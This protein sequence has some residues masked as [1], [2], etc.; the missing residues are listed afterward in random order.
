MTYQ[1]REWNVHTLDEIL[2]DWKKRK[3]DVEMSDSVVKWLLAGFQEDSSKL[4]TW[5]KLE[6]WPDVLGLLFD[7][8][9]SLLFAYAMLL[10]GS[11]L[12]TGDK[13][14]YPTLD[15]SPRLLRCATREQF[16]TLK[17]IYAHKISRATLEI[18]ALGWFPFLAWPKLQKDKDWNRKILPKLR[19]R[20]AR[21]PCASAFA[22]KKLL[23]LVPST[24]VKVPVTSRVSDFLEV[25][26]VCTAGKPVSVSLSSVLERSDWWPHH[27]IERDRSHFTQTFITNSAKDGDLEKISAEIA[28]LKATSFLGDLPLQAL[29]LKGIR[30]R[31][32]GHLDTIMRAFQE[33]AN[34]RVVVDN[35]SEELF[36]NRFLKYDVPYSL[37][38]L[39]LVFEKRRYMRN[40]GV[41]VSGE[42]WT[43]LTNLMD[44]ITPVDKPRRISEFTADLFTEIIA[45]YSF[46]EGRDY[47]AAEYPELLRDYDKLLEYGGAL[48]EHEDEY[49]AMDNSDL[50]S[51]CDEF[52]DLDFYT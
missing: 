30:E 29:T 51:V 39:W 26:K 46:K 11:D 23:T 35:D 8:E 43:I 41:E 47:V 6:Y 45:R 42:E 27:R 44:F 1:G 17:E 49:M 14:M 19:D 37:I 7:I 52:Y 25:V 13:A 2:S 34:S 21:S 31:W 20:L 9:P 28:D 16:R 4:T 15:Y 38:V 33:L 36:E 24:Q 18:K 10:Q 48:V 12:V 40:A 3:L 5:S 50:S 32:E 22:R